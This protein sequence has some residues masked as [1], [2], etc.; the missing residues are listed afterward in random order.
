M[1]VQEYIEKHGLTMT[2][3]P[4]QANPHMDDM[5]KGSGHWRVTIRKADGRGEI[6]TPYSMGP[7]HRTEP[8]KLDGVLESLSS[9]WSAVDGASFEEWAGDLGYDTDSRKA[10]RIYRVC[11]ESANVARGVLGPDVMMELLRD[12]EW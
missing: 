7:A 12:V 5:P 1:T 8:P 2:A 3:E 9:D 6:V 11:L 10:E 4:A